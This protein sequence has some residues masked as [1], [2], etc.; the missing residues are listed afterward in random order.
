M[1]DIINIADR[2]KPV[3]VDP[4]WFFDL[5]VW[6]SLEGE[7]AV[8]T[9]FDDTDE[10]ETADRLRKMAKALDYL[11][12]LMLQQAED[13]EPS[14]DGVPLAKMTVF[15]SSRVRLRINDDRV[16]TPEQEDWLRE[17]FEDAKGIVADNREGR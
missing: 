17:R 7:T 9:A 2:R 6:D 14:D 16:A 5:R 15:E 10:L 11:S 13:M 1:A 8:I 3:T 4:Q 12:Y